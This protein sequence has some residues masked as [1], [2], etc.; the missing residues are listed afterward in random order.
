VRP[1]VVSHLNAEATQL[2]M[3][4]IYFLREK[5]RNVNMTVG[6]LIKCNSCA[7]SPN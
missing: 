3:G 4:G 1:L 5:S 6:L 7:E 2:A